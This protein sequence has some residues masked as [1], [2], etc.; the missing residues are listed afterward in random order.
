MLDES[1]RHAPLRLARVLDCTN[2]LI[3]VRALPNLRQR[4]DELQQAVFL[5]D[6][7]LRAVE[8]IYAHHNVFGGAITLYYRIDGCLQVQARAVQLKLELCCL[9]DRHRRDDRERAHAF[10]ASDPI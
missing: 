9:G 6:R 4:H 7:D 10:T 3:L 1:L 2:E 5:G 8:D